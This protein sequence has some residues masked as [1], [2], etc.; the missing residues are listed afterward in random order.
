LADDRELW[1]RI[2]RGDAQAFDAIYRETGPRLLGFLRQ[3]VGNPQ[4]AEDVMQE[5]FTQIWRAPNGYTPEKGT[6]RTYMFGAARRRAA[7]WWRKQGSANG[8]SFSESAE[9]KTEVSSLV[10]DAL[11]RLPEEQR[12]LLWLREVEGQSYAELAQILDIPIG[13]VRSRL[14]TARERLRSVWNA[15]RPIKKEDA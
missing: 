10:A 3:I 15:T 4:A 1:E 13:T 6:L 14:F 7:E 8:H 11:R 2:R 9:C 12:S 5:T